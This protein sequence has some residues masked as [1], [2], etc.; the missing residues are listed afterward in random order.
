MDDDQDETILPFVPVEE[1]A[2]YTEIQKTFRQLLVLK[3]SHG[4]NLD[5]L[6]DL[7]EAVERQCQELVEVRRVFK[8]IDTKLDALNDQSILQ[9]LQMAPSTSAL[10]IMNSRRMSTLLRQI[11]TQKTPTD[12]LV[13]Q[14]LRL[15]EQLLNPLFA[16]LSPRLFPIYTRLSDIYSQLT[17][18]KATGA[19][20]VDS[21]I[22]NIQHAL[23]TVENTHYVDGKFVD[24]ESLKIASEL[25]SAAASSTSPQIPAEQILAGQALLSARLHSCYRLVHILVSQVESLSESLAPVHDRLVEI[26]KELASMDGSSNSNPTSFSTE[27]VMALQVELRSID[28]LRHHQGDGSAG[29]GSFLELDS[30]IPAGQAMVIELLENCFEK[31]HGLL[32]QKDPVVGPLR[33]TYESLIG[34]KHQLTDIFHER[35]IW[36]IDGQTDEMNA[37]VLL[38]QGQLKLLCQNRS[39]KESTALHDVGD[40]E[41]VI[42]FLLHKCF[43][44]VYKILLYI[45]LMY[46][47]SNSSEEGSSFQMDPTLLA[48]HRQLLSIRRC[49][50]ELKKHAPWTATDLKPWEMSLA[51]LSKHV[52]QHEALVGFGIIVALLDECIELTIEMEVSIA[53]GESPLEYQNNRLRQYKPMPIANFAA[54]S[55][56]SSSAGM[57]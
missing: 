52:L 55:A 27:K 36:T 17:S 9:E 14:A 20:S 11:S 6:L 37:R 38:F 33:P 54:S 2:I 31:C 53:S 12:V 18:F 32:S 45:N 4:F 7:Q 51:V 46:H 47:T 5:A 48:I 44:L 15:I 26:Y 34:I 28:S 56:S 30:S 35:H 24:E 16:T 10:G 43:R 57:H 49:L 1:L 19:Y 8:R 42:H 25:G 39:A 29:P 3:R 50:L 22:I 23:R 41:A 13:T 21:D 40:G